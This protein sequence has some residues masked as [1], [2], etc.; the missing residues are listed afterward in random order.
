MA[1]PHGRRHLPHHCCPA[2]W[3]GR[4]P[5]LTPARRCMLHSPRPF[6]LA[7]AA[8]VSHPLPAAIQALSLS[9]QC[10]TTCPLPR[11]GRSSG[12]S[13]GRGCRGERPSDPETRYLRPNI[14][15][16]SAPGH[17]AGIT[18]RRRRAPSPARSRVARAAP[19]RVALGPR[20]WQH[21]VF[22]GEVLPPHGSAASPCCLLVLAPNETRLS[23][24][25]GDRRV[26]PHS[27]T[28]RRSPGLPPAH[29]GPHPCSAGDARPG[30][31]PAPATARSPLPHPSSPTS[32]DHSQLRL[33]ANL[34]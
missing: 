26:L 4:V 24:G 29:C 5:P 1:G 30:C 7:Q 17:L 13:P 12:R 34:S 19:P 27:G 9:P 6:A 8:W 23:P 31:T 33:A 22:L 2:P 15:T 25:S 32:T 20:R 10:W 18:G 14:P 16:T 11:I 3:G 21:E 28:R